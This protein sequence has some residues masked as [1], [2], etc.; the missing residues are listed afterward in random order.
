MRRPIFLGS[1]YPVLR[2]MA[3]RDANM[4]VCIAAMCDNGK[5][6]VCATD[7]GITFD[8]T[9]QD[10]DMFKVR[11][12]QNPTGDLTFL[13][14]GITG[15]AD[16]IIDKFIDVTRPADLTSRQDIQKALKAAYRLR[17][18]EWIAE[19]VLFPWSLD[20]PE[21]KKSGPQI[22]GSK[23]YKDVVEDIERVT[24]EEFLEQVLMIGWG[25]KE[26]SAMI[27]EVGPLGC[28]T[29]TSLGWAVIGSGAV[30]ASS[31]LNQLAQHRTSPLE[32]T[33]YAVAAAKFAAEKSPRV[34]QSTLSM[35]VS[36]K[37]LPDQTSRY[38]LD[39][40]D[41]K[42]L[43]QLW[44]DHGKPRI[45]AVVAIELKQTIE[46]AGSEIS[47]RSTIRDLQNLMKK[48]SKTSSTSSSER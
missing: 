1:T 2:T 15:Q 36:W 30:V 44:E 18:E 13:Y 4:T 27:Y 19:R 29:H 48:S 31:V 37:K 41:I 8:S 46:K 45:P 40:T 23:K 33:L 22:L 25:F 28:L 20:L 24:N 35:S 11:W 21:F 26:H 12:F 9:T 10:V 43:R 6:V 34:G 42:V 14:A 32:D 5:R 47:T 3:K 16:L 39:D 17:Y 7:G 38:R